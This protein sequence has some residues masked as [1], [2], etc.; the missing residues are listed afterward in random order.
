M[1]RLCIASLAAVGLLL[2][3]GIELDFAKQ[4]SASAKPAA[5][6]VPVTNLR[7]TRQSPSDLEVGGELA[8]LPAGATHYIT[9][10]DLLA[11]PQVAYTVT[12]DSNFT[13]PTK[14]SGVPLEELIQSLGAAPRS[15]MV[16]A[17]CDDKYRANYPREY[18]A[19]HHP[20][21]VLTIEGQPPSGW[22][23]DPE[24]HAY[25]MGPYLISHPKFAPSFK[26]YS[27]SEEPQI[28][29]GVVRIEL[30]NE[31][32]VFGAILPRGSRAN[33]TLVKAG[34]RIA[35]QNCFH[36]HHVGREGGQKSGTPW[37][38]LSAWATASPEYFAAYVRDPQAKNPHA[39]MPGNSRYDDATISAL[40]A[41]F[42]TFS[43]HSPE[44]KP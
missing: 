29:W 20:L 7:A 15:D 3:A 11:L 35:Q 6:S 17:I 32:T 42:Q 33:T 21:L 23:K 19:A 9:R 36:C 39:Q 13:E 18:V 26:I 44:G 28:P 27:H 8:G 24:V 4:Q 2:T 43:P 41:Y 30:R 14:I 38:V 37:L 40:I 34:Y 5:H 22:P 1:R 31:S 12:D 10:E 16:V 25:D